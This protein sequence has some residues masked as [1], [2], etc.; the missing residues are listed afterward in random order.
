MTGDCHRDFS[1]INFFCRYHKTSRV[2]CRLCIFTHLSIIYETNRFILSYLDQS[3]VDKSTEEWLEGIHQKLKYKKWYLGHYH[4]NRHYTDMEMLYEEIRE[5]GS[6]NHIQ[7]LGRPEFNFGDRVMFYAE[8]EEEYYCG[9]IRIID[10]YG[11]L[12]QVQEVSYDIELLDGT[13]YK[14]VRESLI[15]KI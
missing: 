2:E 13:L 3:R 11:T 6:E 15:D 14:H 1:K 10:K 12:G 8:R 4:A 5:I 7:R 9:E